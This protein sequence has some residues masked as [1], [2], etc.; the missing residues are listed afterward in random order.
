MKTIDKSDRR[1]SWQGDLMILRVTQKTAP[2]VPAPS[3]VL[4]HSESGHHHVASDGA[5]VW[6]GPD[7]LTLLLTP[8]PGADHVDIVHKKVGQDAHETIRVLWDGPDD[9]ILVRRGRELRGG[10]WGEMID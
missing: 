5:R 2:T 9:E 6:Q 3:S 1:P 7:A 8:A 4:A 10:K